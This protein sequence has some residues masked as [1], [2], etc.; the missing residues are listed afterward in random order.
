[1]PLTQP[2]DLV[3]MSGGLTPSV[4]LLSQSRGKLVWDEHLQA[5]LP[6]E[7]GEHSRS[8]GACR[9]IFALAAAL[10]DGAAAGAAAARDALA[11]GRT[12]VHAGAPA[13]RAPRRRS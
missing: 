9:G 4:H 3:L 10:A 5:F 12:G 2:C 8:A 13:R 6:G 7:P 1:M 11:P